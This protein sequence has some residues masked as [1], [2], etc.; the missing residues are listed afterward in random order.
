MR[1][2]HIEI[3]QVGTASVAEGSYRFLDFLKSPDFY[4]AIFAVSR[5][6]RPTGKL[7]GP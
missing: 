5:V 1:G 3:Y 4:F 2:T 6:D 7:Q